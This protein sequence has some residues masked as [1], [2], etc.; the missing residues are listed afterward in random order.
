METRGNDYVLG[1]SDSE[2]QRLIAQGRLFGDLTDDVFRRAG[3]APGMRVLDIGRGRVVPRLAARRADGARHRSRSIRGCRG[4][5]A[6]ARGG[7]EA[8]QVRFVAADLATYRPEAP[9]D[10]V[11]G[12][13]VLLYLPEPAAVLR[14]LR[15]HVQP[16]GLVC[17]HEFDIPA[18]GASRRCRSSPAIVR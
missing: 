8:E 15:Q 16:G 1:H 17:F 6:T 5:G 11:V 4:A 14:E 9:F 10:A 7:G 13:L 3:L 2:L 18:R 12:R